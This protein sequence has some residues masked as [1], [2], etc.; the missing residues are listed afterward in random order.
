MTDTSASLSQPLPG[1]TIGQAVNR[2]FKKYATFTGRASRSEYWWVVLFLGLINIVFSIIFAVAGGSM[3][4]AADGS[5]P[6]PS[7]A[8]IAVIVI[9]SLFA[10][11]VLVPGIAVTIRRLHDGN[12]SGWF[13]LLTFVGLSIVVFILTLFDSKP[14]GARFDA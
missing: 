5:V 4:M 7:G 11:A 12:F 14:E 3:T 13:Y 6:T 10:L 9:W 1:A 8:A 2:F